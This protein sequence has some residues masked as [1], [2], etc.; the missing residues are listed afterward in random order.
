V[1]Q[2]RDWGQ[3]EES[4]VKK[5]GGIVWRALAVMVK[6]RL[7]RGGEGSAPRALSLIWRLSERVQRWAAHR[8]L[9]GCT[10]GVVS[11]LR[12]M[13]ETLRDPVHPGQGGRPRLQRWRHGLSAQV[14][15]RYERRRGVETER[16][17]VEG[18]LAR[19][20]ALQRR[21]QGDGVLHTADMERL[22]AT[23]RAHLA[24]L[25]RRAGHWPATP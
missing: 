19:V 9:C 10:D 4:R 13:R 11:S 8:P 23:L 12:A 16:R 15:K 18:T 1:E 6:T 20:E 14:V 24:P 21:S 3:A 5:Q 17:L 25:A 2:S 7:W 22:T